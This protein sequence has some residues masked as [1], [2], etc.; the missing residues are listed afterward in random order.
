MRIFL[1]LNMLISACLPY[2]TELNRSLFQVTDKTYLA[3]DD[4][5]TIGEAILQKDS[6]PYQLVAQLNAAGVITM[7][8]RVIAATGWT[9]ASLIQGLERLIHP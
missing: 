8:P 5:C 7:Q 4:S 1:F 9:S 6:F 2:K 3:L